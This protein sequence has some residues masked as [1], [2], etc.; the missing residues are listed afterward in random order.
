MFMK[1]NILTDSKYI[2][3]INTSLKSV[4]QQQKSP[5]F[6]KITITL[7]CPQ[8]IINVTATFLPCFNTVIVIYLF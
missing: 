2:V 8:Y 7:E 1:A 3:I 4:Y 6:V 5:N